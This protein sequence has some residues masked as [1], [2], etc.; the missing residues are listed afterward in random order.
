MWFGVVYM[1]FGLGL[2]WFDLGLTLQVDVIKRL[3]NIFLK[4]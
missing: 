4:Y 2:T 1:W 3:L